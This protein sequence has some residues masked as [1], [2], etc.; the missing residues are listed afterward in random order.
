M[1][2]ALPGA[3]ENGCDEMMWS[4]VN[5]GIA[6]VPSACAVPPMP[7]STEAPSATVASA[8]PS[9]VRTRFTVFLPCAPVDPLCT[10]RTKRT[11]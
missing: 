6:G 1:S 5:S 10:D 4:K 2:I 3:P 11:I 8:A 9:R 7:T